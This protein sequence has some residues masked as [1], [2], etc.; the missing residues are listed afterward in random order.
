MVILIN[1]LQIFAIVF[2]FIYSIVRVKKLK[3]ITFEVRRGERCYGCSDEVEHDDVDYMDFEAFKASLEREDF[4]LCVACKREE[5]LDHFIKSGFPDS[6]GINKFKRFLFSKKSDRMIWY[7]MFAVLTSVL[8]EFV[9]RFVFGVKIF[10]LLTPICNIV[11][12][13]LFCYKSK[14]TYIKE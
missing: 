4:K 14:I 10:W 6:T 12:W 1:L 9:A 5:N 13:G 2:G 3:P 7:F 11:Y 8:V